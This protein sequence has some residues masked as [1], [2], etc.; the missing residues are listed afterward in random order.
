[1]MESSEGFKAS[2]DNE[3]MFDLAQVDALGVGTNWHHVVAGSVAF[4]LDS[5]D[6]WWISATLVPNDEVGDTPTH[7]AWFP[8]YEVSGYR[9]INASSTD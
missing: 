1:M 6:N 9:V 8:S 4:T 2:D 5:E 7:T 3:D